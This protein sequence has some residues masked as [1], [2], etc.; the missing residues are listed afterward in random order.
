MGLFSRR[1]HDPSPGNGSTAR[2]HTR[3]KYNIDSGH[4][5]RRPSFGQWLKATWLDILT[6]ALMGAV[7]LGV[8]KVGD[9]LAL[10]LREDKIF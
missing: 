2:N 6:M 7:G 8:Y 10:L 3:E 9:C 1:R 4:F 5:N